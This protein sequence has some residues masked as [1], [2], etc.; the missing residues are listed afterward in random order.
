MAVKKTAN[1]TAAAQHRPLPGIALL[2]AICRE[3]YGRALP[4]LKR[5]LA[6]VEDLYAG[7]W[8][9]HEACEVPY[10][11]FA[12]ALDAAVA[13]ARMAVGWNRSHPEVKINANLFCQAVAAGLF[14]DAGYIKDKGDH[15][16]H[17]GKFTT[18]HVQRGMAIAAAYLRRTR[19][20]KRAVEL[21]PATIALTDYRQEPEIDD[22]FRDQQELAMARMIPTA[23]LIAQV[24]DN[25]YIDKLDGLFAEFTEMYE[26]QR[27]NGEAGV[28]VFHSVQEIRD[29]VLE[30]YG[31]FVAPRLEKFGR[32]DRYL[33]SYFGEN[34]NPYHENI[35]ANLSNHLFGSDVQWRQLGTILQELGVVDE[36]LLATALGRQRRRRQAAREGKSGP[37]APSPRA[38]LQHWLQRGSG[39]DSLGDILLDM[40]ALSPT[41]LAHGLIQQN[42]PGDLPAGLEAQELRLLLRIAMV[43]QHLGKSP[44]LLAAVMELLNEL[45]SCE[46]GSLMLAELDDQ[47]MLIALPTGPHGAELQG[48]RIPADKGLAGWVLRNGK[49]ALTADTLYDQRFDQSL[50]HNLKFTTRS[51]LAVPLIINGDC[52]GVLEAIN[53]IGGTFTQQD[54]QKLTIAANMLA[55]ALEGMIAIAAFPGQLTPPAAP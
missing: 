44:R 30:F 46:A 49:P 11:D 35:A 14:H 47:E 50:D 18:T 36:Q 15:E 19:W 6:D 20:H 31:Q 9:S 34:R 54:L 39:S 48:R 25:R 3:E 51:L 55:G 32:M 29:G 41:A 5:L 21:V 28:P 23:D 24:A 53:K 52:L 37:P 26:Y 7:R 43:I 33:T 45:L 42:L 17:G 1:Q 16:G 27:Q 10:H 38:A 12:H 13:V 4:R 40:E 2:L 22:F 8:P